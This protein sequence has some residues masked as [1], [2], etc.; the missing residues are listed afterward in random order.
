MGDYYMVKHPYVEQCASISQPT[1]ERIILLT[2]SQIARGM[3][4][5]E[6]D[7]RHHVAALHHPLEYNF[8]IHYRSGCAAAAYLHAVND[9]VVARQH[10]YPEFLMMNML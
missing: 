7:S 9:T 1:R 6:Y 2:G 4:M 3:V 8:R 5:H 10:Y